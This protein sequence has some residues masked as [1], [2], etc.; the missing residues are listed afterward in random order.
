MGI[1]VNQIKIDSRFLSNQGQTAY[2]ET[3]AFLI[4]NLA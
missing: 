3:F 4:K 1:L 2:I